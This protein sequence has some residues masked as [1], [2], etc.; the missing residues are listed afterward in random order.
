MKKNKQAVCFRLP[1][2]AS[3]LGMFAFN[4]ALADII[5]QES[6]GVVVGECELFSS[7]TNSAAGK[8]W[9]IVPGEEAGAGTNLNARGGAYVQCLPDSGIGGGP[10]VPPLISYQMQI[11]TPGA[12]RLYIRREGNA[13]DLNTAGSS[14]SLFMD[15]E[16]L[17]DG[18]AGVFG[19]PTNAI[20]DWYEVA[21]NVDGDFATVPWSSVCA[22][23]TNAAGASGFNANWVIPHV[24]V[25]TLR[26]SQRE[27]GAALDA[28]VFQLASL[29]APTGD[30]PAR[31]ALEQ[32]RVAFEAAGDTFLKRD[33]T[34]VPHGTNTELVIKNDL[35]AGPSGLDRTVYLRFDISALSALE[36]MVLTNASLKIG[37]IT[38]GI[39]T[40]HTI[41]V[42]VIAEDATAETFDEATL[43]PSSS[44]VWSG[45]SDETV[46]LSKVYGN[47]PVGSFLIS[48]S[49]NGK[50][51]TFGS[52]GLLNAIRADTDGVLSLILYRTEDH[53]AGDNFASKEYATLSP[54]LLEVGFRGKLSGTAIMIH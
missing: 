13:S 5:Y 11:F 39:G 47:A 1:V 48:A 9:F 16:E 25:Y 54:P 6:G 20:A 23:E 38:E 40:N 21:G 52:L 4:Q 14:D 19:S 41:S 35:G 46:D 51:V 28:W 10:N 15:I 36:G 18:T 44:D 43:T 24:G 2:F 17:K 45:T 34:A 49:D 7:R 30:G 42:A 12:Y 50:T 53:S 3:L 26:F 31:S 37:Q 8:G 32:S 22:P 27:D 33:D 29:P